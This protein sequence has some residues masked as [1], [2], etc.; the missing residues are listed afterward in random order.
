VIEYHR[1]LAK[2]DN[3]GS[4]RCRA[5]LEVMELVEGGFSQKGVEGAVQKG[6]GQEGHR[7]E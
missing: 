6:C 5:L 1:P 2:G 7:K 3:S 4:L